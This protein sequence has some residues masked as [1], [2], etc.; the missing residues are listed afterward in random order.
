MPFDMTSP[1][2]F[3]FNKFPQSG[4]LLLGKEKE[5]TKKITKA[6][7][8]V[9]PDFE[10]EIAN[11]VGSDFPLA[12][13]DFEKGQNNDYKKKIK[14][15]TKDLDLGIVYSEKTNKLYGISGNKRYAI[16][17]NKTGEPLD[18]G[19]GFKA[20]EV[21]KCVNKPK[22]QKQSGK[23]KDNL[24]KNLENRIGARRA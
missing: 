6:L 13:V 7:T 15:I 22:N 20:Y 17:K 19:D 3:Y 18:F 2:F 16:A 21:G 8:I 5:K 11:S 14:C 1:S 24:I 4:T 10:I 23:D 12:I 9:N